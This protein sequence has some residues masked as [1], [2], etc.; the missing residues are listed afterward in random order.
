MYSEEHK[1]YLKKRKRK[2]FFIRLT[3]ISIVA[4]FIIIW[5]LLADFNLINTFIT[6]TPKEI[7]NTILS[8]NSDGS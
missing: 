7:V 4:I 8:L 6:S 2:N 5:Q 3:Q 1:L